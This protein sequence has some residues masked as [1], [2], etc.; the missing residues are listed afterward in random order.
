MSFTVH[1]LQF[2]ETESN[3]PF[4]YGLTYV[5]LAADIKSLDKLPFVLTPG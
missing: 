4:S 5:T 1:F 2:A 3:L